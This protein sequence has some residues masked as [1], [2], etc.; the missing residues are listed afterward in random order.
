[1]LKAIIRVRLVSYVNIGDSAFM[2]DLVSRECLSQ[3]DKELGIMI[4]SAD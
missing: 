1:M 4:P 3:V 2:V